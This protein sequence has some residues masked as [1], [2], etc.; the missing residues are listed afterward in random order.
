MWGK[1]MIKNYNKL[2]I[3]IMILLMAVSLFS[4]TSNAEQI[5]GS[6]EPAEQAEENTEEEPQPATGTIS[7]R[8]VDE[9]GVE[10]GETFEREYN[11]GEYT[12]E[13]MHIPGYDLVSPA[14]QSV[15][16]SADGEQKVIIFEYRSQA[17]VPGPD[18]EPEPEEEPGI[19]EE[20]ADQETTVE[21]IILAA[22]P[23][24]TTYSI[25][26]ELNLAGLVVY[27]ILSD[28]KEEEIPAADLTVSGFNSE[29]AEAE[30]VVTIEYDGFSAEFTVSIEEKESD[31]FLTWTLENPIPSL[32]I[33]LVF[34]LVVLSVALL[35][36]S[37]KKPAEKK[38]IPPQEE[39]RPKQK[40]GT[41]EKTRKRALYII[42]ITVV[43]LIILGYAGSLFLL[44]QMERELI[45]Q[46]DESL[47][48]EKGVG[49]RGITNIAIFGID[50]EDGMSGRS[51]AIMILTLDEVHKKIK[52][53]SLMRDSYVDIPGRG[54]DKI[55][56]AYSFGG[57][58]L[59][60]KTINQNLKLDNRHYVSVNFT[61]MPAI[62]DA[63]GGVEVVITDRE[64]REL[65]GISGGGT[66][67]LNGE[68]ALR[69]SRIRK[70][71]SD[72]ERTRRQR[73]IMEST[74]ESALNAP[75]TSY[76]VMLG[77]VFPHLTT[78]LT[79]NQI[80][81]LGS[82]TL[83]KNMNTIEQA[84]FPTPSLGRGQMISGVYYYV[85]DLVEGARRLGRFI[86][87][88]EPLD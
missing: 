57:P 16:L 52:I 9:E 13:A 76:P 43:G 75:V 77:K 5:D 81:N 73:D 6:R 39:K 20:R 4:G 71:D 15:T 3:L 37:Q 12:F 38:T 25:G 31:G 85:F 29:R 59:A 54:M 10:I 79:S 35:R 47:G 80:M 1:K 56:H 62:I 14:I 53:T 36:K 63:V 48:I 28:G 88:D 11:L 33:I 64:A 8:H 86:Y 42:L 19:E 82:T 60:I 45:S 65:S 2:L 87:H 78:N 67:L 24:K 58:A 46:D 23:Y 34:I 7:L 41:P 17:P 49:R 40:V 74:I 72:F 68:Q 66:H 83:L 32:V 44:S 22:E 55:N 51:D 21:D 30:Q 69:F 61:S 26:E 84:Q 50:S 70:I 18:P 27:K